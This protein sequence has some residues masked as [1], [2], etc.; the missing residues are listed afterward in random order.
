M[1][2]QQLAYAYAHAHTF[3]TNSKLIIAPVSLKLEYIFINKSIQSV[4][5]Q[6][7]YSSNCK[8]IKSR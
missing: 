5:Y 1:D 2:T 4:G 7:T 3:N 8:Y 6:Q